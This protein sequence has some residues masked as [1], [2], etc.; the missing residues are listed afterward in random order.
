MNSKYDERFVNG[1]ARYVDDLTFPG[2]LY[3]G[4]VRSPYAR[5]RL[6]DVKGG[7]SH[8]EMPYKLSSVGEGASEGFE[9]LEHPV[10]A[11]KYVG[12]VGQPVAAVYSDNR[13]NIED[14]IESVD[15]SYE[16]L[17][18]IMDPE[19]S[20]K[21][22]PMYPGLKSNL[23]YDGYRGTD[24]EIKDAPLILEDKFVNRRIVANPIEPR[25][26]LAAYDGRRLTVWASTQSVHSLKEGFCE[27][28]N[29]KPEDVRVIQVDTGG[30]FGTKG[31]IYPEYIIAAA[32]AMKEKRPVKWIETRSEHLVSTRPGR[33]VVGKMKLYADR[34][35]KILGLKGDIIVDTGAFAGGSGEFSA[36]FIAMQIT[37]PYNIRKAYIHAMS[38]L[39]NK[40][41]QG[42]YRGAGRPEASFFM[43]RM[44]DLLADELKMDP[45]DLRILN[46][47]TEPFTS[48]T[49][50]Q[51][52]ASRPFIEAAVK[53]L[54]YEKYRGKSGVGFS[55]FVLVPATM[56]GESAK[57]SVSDG[58][59]RVWL[60]G[61]AH[62]Q[63][64]DRFV[65]SIIE[66]ELG[67]SEDRI[68]FQL[69]DTDQTESGVGSWGSRSAMMGGSALVLAARKIKKL[70]ESKYGKYSPDAL[71][72][73]KW[74]S[75]EFFNYDKP[76]NSLGANL[77]AVDVGELGQ[78]K[79][80]ECASY[81]DVGNVLNEKNAINQI[82]G[83]C[84]QGVGQ[85]LFEELAFDENGQ[86]MTSSIADAGVPT[87]DL[88][89]RFKAKLHRNPSSLPSGAKGVGESP[90]IGVPS[91]LVRA[92]ETA[93]GV[94]IRDT[95]ISQEKLLE[96]MGILS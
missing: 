35:G 22:E 41:V 96:G 89:P 61:N 95:P 60:G 54:E 9:F 15:V 74:E 36:P 78:I 39:T 40:V 19:E 32:I 68:D 76:L 2:M 65:A 49:G 8:K 13:Y 59:V 37:G 94:R 33:G 72:N 70:V 85:T 43:E 62:G 77:V 91:A 45:V 75:F 1:S 80:K 58:R 71:L 57:I 53:G 31:G 47:T 73:G 7:I 50:L 28:L 11:N 51:I 84:A 12:Y 42:P 90:T 63:R 24:F 21:S 17:R 46:S 52:E 48:P 79:I 38:V 30:A 81:Y 29:L 93:T 82:V 44:V 26:V 25:G 64:H 4:I 23:L 88:L 27:T 16:P 87:A 10:L 6:L 67:V 56:P 55:F 18:P 5:A 83:G 14:L 86:L 66:N 92:I 34:S 20:I 3:L 69:G